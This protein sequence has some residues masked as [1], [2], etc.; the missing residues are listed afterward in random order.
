LGTPYVKPFEISLKR[1]FFA[2]HFYSGLR[3]QAIALP[4]QVCI[5]AHF[6]LQ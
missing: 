6:V 1:L 4:V 2:P 3:R 5:A